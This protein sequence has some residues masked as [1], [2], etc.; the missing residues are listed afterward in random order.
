MEHQSDHQLETVRAVH[1][2]ELV[3]RPHSQKLVGTVHF[4]TFTPLETLLELVGVLQDDSGRSTSWVKRCSLS[5]T[6]LIVDL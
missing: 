5:R 3:G 2:D 1:E 6:V 4:R